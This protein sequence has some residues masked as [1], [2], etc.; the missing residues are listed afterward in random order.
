MQPEDGGELQLDK[1]QYC[2]VYGSNNNYVLV[3]G[4][5]RMTSMSRLFVFNAKFTYNLEV[6]W[7]G[8]AESFQILKI[9]LLWN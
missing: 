7:N 5:H 1:T 8:H 4:M 2:T 6:F 3:D 9:F